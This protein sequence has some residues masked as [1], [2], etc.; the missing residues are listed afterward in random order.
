MLAGGPGQDANL[1]GVT[2][3][4]GDDVIWSA[5]DTHTALADGMSLDR[6]H[7][8]AGDEIFVPQQRHIQWLAI[9][10]FAV[11]IVGIVYSFTR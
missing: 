3:K 11:S 2:V 8:R 6:M 4:R 7:I 5:Q 1:S 10:G 9:A